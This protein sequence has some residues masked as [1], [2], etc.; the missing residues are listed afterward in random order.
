MFLEQQ[1]II[2]EWFLKDHVTLKTAV[3]MLKIQLRIT[4]INYILQYIQIR[5]VILNGKNISQYNC[6]TVFFK[7]INIALVSRR[8][9]FQKY[10]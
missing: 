6:F 3:M 2:L 7:Q 4:G 5:K 9:F 8:E 10:I 1:I